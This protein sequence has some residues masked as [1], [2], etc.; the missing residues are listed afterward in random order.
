[1]NALPCHQ[2]KKERKKEKIKSIPNQLVHN[3]VSQVTN[4]LFVGVLGPNTSILS[5]HDDV[6]IYYWACYVLIDP[7]MVTTPP[8]KYRRIIID[9][10]ALSNWKR[11][12]IFSD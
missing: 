5:D 8:E 11:R 2:K 12:L 3:I 9:G 6:E 4:N 1:M 7:M 10:T